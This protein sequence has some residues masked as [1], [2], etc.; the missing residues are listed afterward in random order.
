MVVLS[1]SNETR[2]PGALTAE[3]GLLHSVDMPGTYGGF[4]EQQPAGC[5][6]WGT[7]R[8]ARP[9]PQILKSTPQIFKCTPQIY[10]STPQIFK[11][12]PQIYESTHHI[13]ESRTQFY[14]SRPHIYESGPQ[15]YETPNP[16]PLNPTLK[17]GTT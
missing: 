16:K 6:T 3:G 9:S 15:I 10:E 13:Y 17:K 11:F 2:N 1:I 12:T 4:V 7:P 8:T 14:E 5:L